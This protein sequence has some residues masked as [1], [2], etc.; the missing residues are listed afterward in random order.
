MDALKTALK[1][2][3]KSLGFDVVGIATA[4]PF[5]RERAYL[6]QRAS[7]P[8]PFE[9]PDQEA[10]TEPQKILPGVQAIVAVGMTYLMSEAPAPSDPLHG[11]LSRYCRGLD[12][13]ELMETR[14]RALADWLI[15]AVPDSRAYAHV[16][17]GAPL[18]RAVAARAGLGRFGKSTQLISRGFGGWTFLG[19][20]FTTVPLP[21][22]APE[23][24]NVCGACRR[25][26][27]V[28]PTQALR[29]WEIDAN[30]CLGYINQMDGDIPEDLRA[31]L[32]NRLFGCDDC[33]TVCPY[34]HT[35]ARDVHPEFAPLPE[36]GAHPDLRALLAMDETEFTRVYGSTAAA[37]RGLEILQRNAVVALGN[38]GV[39]SARPLLQQA[40]QSPSALLRR[41]AAWALAR[42]DETVSLPA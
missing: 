40:L 35:A 20:L 29:P 25:C 3:A 38:S 37:W 27:D 16:D 12:Y 9:W 10:R 5:A 1:A 14:L 26:L 11:W 22:D 19:E 42:L 39:E 31:L 18:D 4:T 23:S 34:T 33:L 32:G 41:H 30:R 36:P 24:W 21:P 6:T 28:C 13:H 8:N 17:V 7:A 15:A 2:Q